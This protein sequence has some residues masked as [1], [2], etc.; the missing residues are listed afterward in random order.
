VAVVPSKASVAQMKKN[1]EG[2]EERI[3]AKKAELIKSGLTEEEAERVTD[4][5]M[6][7]Y[8]RQVEEV[9]EYEEFYRME[10]DATS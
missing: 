6:S 9:Q 10:E 3:L 5:L 2:G 7:Y 8:L 4:P 1:L